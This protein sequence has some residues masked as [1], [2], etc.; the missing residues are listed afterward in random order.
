MFLKIRWLYI[1]LFALPIIVF[2]QSAGVWDVYDFGAKGDGKTNDTYAIQRAIDNCYNSGGGKILLHNGHFLSRTIRLKSNVTLFI[3][4]SA[5]LQGSRNMD[6]Y[7]TLITDY[8]AVSG[9]F[10]HDKS[11]VYAENAENIAILGNG[12]IDGSG[13]ELEQMQRPRPHCIVIRRCK[14]IKIRDIKIRNAAF[15]VQKYQSCD[16]L[17]IDGITVD[18]R[19]NIDIEKPRFIDV[20]GGRNTDGCDIVDCK[21]VR[22]SNCN[23]NS[24][25]DGIV[26]KS[27]LKNEGCQNITVTNCLITSNASG[28]KIG[29]E[30]AGFFRDFSINNCV[31]YDTRGAAIGIMTVDGGI[32]ERIIVSNITLRN[33]KGTAIFLRLGNRGKIYQKVYEKA[34]IGKISDILIQNIYGTEIERYGC[35]ITGIAQGKPE[36]IMLENINLTFKK[37]SDPLFFEGYPNRVVK[38]LTVDSVPE[39]EETYPRGEMFGKLPSYGFYIRHVKNIEFNDV[40]LEPKEDDKRPAM[41]ADE[42]T[43]LIINKLSA[44]SSPNSKGLIYLRDTENV[45]ISHSSGTSHVPVFLVISGNKSKNIM[46]KDIDF[47]NVDRK[48]LFEDMVKKK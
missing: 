25:D 20:P 11:L 22:I 16:N 4:T 46:L 47:S 33:I 30:S 24:G 45:S 40:R 42:V 41:V 3:E 13:D 19:E 7:P 21:N 26:F 43:G 17:L 15:W 12:T 5:V 48:Y 6:D 34:S 8:P 32:I 35:S 18:S 38:E 2:P 37:G 28:I 29:T 23:I 27:F 44:K 14:N 36:N 31:I 1:A 10:P 39:L 9:E